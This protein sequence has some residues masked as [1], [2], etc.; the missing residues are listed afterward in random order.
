[1]RQ[2]K[3]KVGMI[4]VVTVAVLLGVAAVIAGVYALRTSDKDSDV[5][6]TTRSTD[7]RNA[8]D[9]GLIANDDRTLLTIDPGTLSYNPDGAPGCEETFSTAA[10]TTTVRY[11]SQK[12]GVAFDVP[13]NPDW[14]SEQYRIAPFDEVSTSDTLVFGPVKTGEGCGWGRA[15]LLSFQ[16]QRSAKEAIEAGNNSQ[17]SAMYSVEPTEETISAF[18]VIKSEVVGLCSMPAFEVIGTADYNYSLQINCGEETEKDFN[19]LESIVK[20]FEL[21]Q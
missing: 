11:E 8:G 3:S 19:F 16:P 5:P 15:Y 12:Y 9:S 14:G 17:V 1:M 6:N 13:Y 2:K 10:P 20:T 21:T 4:G 18:T 7:T